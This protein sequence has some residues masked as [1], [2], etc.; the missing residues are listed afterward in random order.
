MDKRS[1]YSVDDI[2]LEYELKQQK[3]KQQQA[4]AAPKSAAERF[5]QPKEESAKTPKSSKATPPKDDTAELPVVRPQAVKA[6]KPVEPD[7][8]EIPAVKAAS[9][10][11]EGDTVQ[12]GPLRPVKTVSEPEK[13]VSVSTHT[14]V[15]T[16]EEPALSGDT[17]ELPSQGQLEGQLVMENFLPETMN[18]Q[19]LREE[20]HRRRQEKVDGFRIIE[21][22]KQPFKL[23]GDEEGDVADEEEDDTAPETAEQEED[24]DEESDDLLEDFNEYAEA[25]A[26]RSEL[27]Y[28]RRMGAIGMIATAGMEAVLILLTVLYQWGWLAFA[29]PAVLTALHAAVLVGMLCL[30]NTMIGAG[31]KSLLKGRADS[32]SPAAVCG[33]IGLIYTVAQFA[34]L[35]DVAAGSA[36]FLS[37]A[38]GLGVLAGAVG[39]QVQIMRI[40]R[41]FSF[42]AGTKNTKYA[43]SFIDDEKTAMEIGKPADIDGIPSIVYYRK[44]PFLTRFLEYS[45][46]AD[47]ADRMMRW[48]VPLSLG[49]SLLCAVGYGLLFPA[50]AWKAPTVFVSSVL[51]TMPV[52][53]LFV[54][55]R[56]MGRSSKKALKSGAMIGGFAAA[57]RFGRRVKYTV[58]EAAELFPKDQ[59]KL[60]GIKTFSGTRIDDAIIDAAAVEI[61]AGG[62]L[63]PIFHRLIENR[64]DILREVDSLAY[65]QDMGLSGWVGGRR[66]LIGNRRLLKNHGVDVPEKDYEAR[67]CKD[68]RNIVYLST[69]GEL[70]AMFVVSYLAAPAIKEQVKALVREH[71]TLLVR[72]CDP[73]IT[74]SLVEEVME[75]PSLSVDVMSAAEGRAYGTLLRSQET[76]RADAMLACGGRGLSKM[77]AVVQCRRL[78]RGAWAGLVALAAAGIAMMAFAAFVTATTGLVLTPMSLVGVMIAFGIVGWMIPKMMKA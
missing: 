39:R 70:S 50:H 77:F 28:R 5:A 9:A 60:H 51:A 41:N 47:P 23:V 72:T 7:T 10:D 12:L 66:V 78:R 21:G 56:T 37:A 59:V 1:E 18:E 53:A 38:A 11:D 36:L 63:S 45:Y 49:V 65:E 8:T 22:G 68:G 57:E 13:V 15:L 16:V 34:S 46:G 42:V 27:V 58:V 33:V 26:I 44:A 17:G 19:E 61:A 54:S 64:T 30:N 3:Q 31:L 43:A 71:I 73:N 35:A 20:L 62:P 76:E 69:G 29:S 48:F 2:L 67:Y 52:W 40:S 14:R 75:L 4:S 25:D 32:D 6:A 55:Q 24:A 74:A